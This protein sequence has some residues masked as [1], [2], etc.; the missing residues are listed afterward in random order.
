[1]RR[2]APQKLRRRRR[3]QKILAGV[4]ARRILFSGGGDA[5]WCRLAAAAEF[6]G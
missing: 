3:L 1:L 4:A 6:G 5:V 2:C